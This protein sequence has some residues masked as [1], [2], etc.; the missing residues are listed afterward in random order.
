M[1]K[2]I[3]KLL[4]IS[5]LSSITCISC[6]MDDESDALGFQAKENVN[7]EEITPEDTSDDDS[8][9]DLKP[10]L[11]KDSII[12][13]NA[14]DKIRIFK[15]YF[16]KSLDISKPI[17]LIFRFHGS[18]S[19]NPINDIS[20]SHIMNKLANS[21]NII[22]VFPLGTIQ[23]GTSTYN[24]NSDENLDFFDA[25]IEYFKASKNPIIDTD[26]IYA[27]GQSSGAIFSYHLA[28]KRSEILAAI[29]PISGQYKIVDEDFEKPTRTVAIRGINGID[30]DIVN[31]PSSVNNISIWAERVGEYTQLPTSENVI[32]IEDNYN[33]V[34]KIE[35]VA[36]VKYWKGGSNDIEFF[37][38]RNEGH[39]VNWGV[40]LPYLWD[41]MKSH[42]LN[43][44][45][46]AYILLPSQTVRM[47][48]GT[49]KSINYS[50][51]INTNFAVKSYPKGWDVV[52]EEDLV[53]ITAPEQGIGEASG[54]II[55]SLTKDGIESEKILSVEGKETD[56]YSVGQFIES[57]DNYKDKLGIVYWVDPD[58][59]YKAKVFTCNYGNNGMYTYYKTGDGVFK[60]ID[61]DTGLDIGCTSVSNGKSN[62]NKI[63][64]A[65][66]SQ[67]Y[68]AHAAKHCSK[69]RPGF[70][71][72]LPSINEL[73]EL[74]DKELV[75]KLN[76]I[77]IAN[78]L[79]PIAT[80]K[81]Y[82]SSTEVK[83]EGRDVQVF[84]RSVEGDKDVIANYDETDI[85]TRGIMK[86]G[87]WE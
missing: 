48:F 78:K 20:E 67:L 83:V 7:I 34:N 8:Y 30:D 50:I 70:E 55:F 21:E 17:S 52:I 19:T 41:F 43:D 74:L 47:K 22:M 75:N 53:K 62:T 85:H 68:Y 71:A 35:Y 73:A 77:L 18:T 29:V 40:M 26:R 28:M 86:V 79:D 81:L 39:G 87:D 31:Y 4:I 84:C 36:E 57:N 13:E 44:G 66:P 10:G 5:I 1:K 24:W 25:M 16:P 37:G 82:W 33:T 58:N 76:P 60:W 6:I 38:I 9:S 46:G 61:K 72:Y 11:H 51:S 59:K 15:Y 2:I 42:T 56:G 63:L 80:D 54:D 27:C 12:F 69:Y 45:T 49:T 65:Y 3:Y 23:D 64:E 14:K 32:E